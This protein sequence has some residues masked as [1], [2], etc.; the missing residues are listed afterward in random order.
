MFLAFTVYRVAPNFKG[1]D[2][3]SHTPAR[4]HSGVK[5]LQK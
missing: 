3:H 4:D 1:F 2:R 5:M